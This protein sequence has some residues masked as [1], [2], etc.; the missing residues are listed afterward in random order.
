[1]KNENPDPT[2]RFS[3]RV[4]SYVRHRPG[5][6]AA[7]HDGLRI[8]R[9]LER[10]DVV[11]D[12]GSGTGILSELFLAAGH[13]VL[14]VEPNADMRAA[15]E[16]RLAAYARFHSIDGSA[17]KSTLDRRSVDLAVA[18]QAFHWFDRGRARAE[19]LRILRG[20][21]RAALLWNDRKTEGSAFSE[22]YEALLRSFGTDYA[23]VDHKNLTRET[24]D[25]FFGAGRWTLVS[26]SNEQRFDLDGLR[27]RL[28]SSSYAPAPGQP[29]H[30]E[31]MREL[32]ATFAATNEGGFVRMEY[33]TR[34]YLG[35]LRSG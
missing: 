35:R 32:D 10:Q 21:A 13:E 2:K 34:I 14:G 31:M 5:Y 28:L 17:E 33:D 6:P 3:N 1:M 8:E 7:V 19:F 23:A 26:L 12:V 27:G 20:K 30:D 25:R 15:A 9:M 22:R 24:F 18:G 16:K 4:E 11:T 29:R